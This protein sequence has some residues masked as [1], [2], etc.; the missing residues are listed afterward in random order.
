MWPPRL[1][2]LPMRANSPSARSRKADNSHHPPPHH[3]TALVPNA[4]QTQA[5]TPDN[6]RKVVKWLG[7]SPVP[8][9]GATMIRASRW[10]Q[11]VPFMGYRLAS[12]TLT[13][14]LAASPR[15]ARRAGLAHQAPPLA[16][17]SSATGQSPSL[18]TGRIFGK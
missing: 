5:A 6:R 7:R 10:V 8:I 1:I 18:A 17:A 15:D 11:D 4:K 12:A 13:R 16:D 2:I 14:Q 9:I 3:V